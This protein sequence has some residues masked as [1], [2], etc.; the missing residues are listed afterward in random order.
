MSTP[1][2]KTCPHCGTLAEM[3][4]SHCSRCAQMFHGPSPMP[5]YGAQTYGP[6]PYATQAG[7]KVPAGVCGILLG[8]LGIHKFLMGYIMEG[9]IMLMITVIGGIFTFG[10]ASGLMHV[11]G[12]VEGILYVSKSDEEFVNTYVVHRKGWF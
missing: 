7:M 5:P 11:V 8:S 2:Y 1:Q 3:N 6:N 10:L 9:I 12:L 4:A